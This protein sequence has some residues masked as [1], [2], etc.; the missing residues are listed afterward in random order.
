MA[1]TS[2]GSMRE[3]AR[4]LGV[5]HQRVGRWLREG[6]AGGVKSIPEAAQ[7]AIDTVFVQ[8]AR[9]VAARAKE[10]GIPF[11]KSFPVMMERKPLATG[12]M[13]D[14]V[15]V[16]N[17]QFIRRR[18]RES[19]F[20]GAVNSQKFYTGAVRSIVNLR[21]YFRGRAVEEIRRQ[22]RRDITPAELARMMERSFVAKERREKGRV[23]DAAQP[24]PL[25]TG[26][27]GLRIQRG[28]PLAVQGI[29]KQLREKHSPATSQPDTV[30]A[31]QYLFQL[32]PSNYVE[33]PQ[34]KRRTRASAKRTVRGRGNK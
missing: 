15:F 14:R 11:N 30:A 8:H 5:T 27:E 16:E 26:R 13:G 32:I 20:Q 23:I 7:D 34:A 24:F 28:D 4:Q 2:A 31:D 22:K 19:V 25:Y 3:L 10:F 21:S 18:V 33:A 9:Y 1:L 17:T 29:E 6:E 12:K